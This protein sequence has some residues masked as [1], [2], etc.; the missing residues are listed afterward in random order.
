MLVT[1]GT[2]RVNTDTSL[3]RIVCFVSRER[4]K[5]LT[6]SLNSTRLIRTPC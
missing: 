2:R 1:I 5:A 6:F 3:L 4:I